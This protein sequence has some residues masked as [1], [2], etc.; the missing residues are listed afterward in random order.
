MEWT[1]IVQMAKRPRDGTKTRNRTRVRAKER[2]TA[3]DG[4]GEGKRVKREGRQGSQGHR[5]RRGSTV[6]DGSEARRDGE[7]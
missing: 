4:Q 5:P 7:R 1:V 6:E 2:G 3:R